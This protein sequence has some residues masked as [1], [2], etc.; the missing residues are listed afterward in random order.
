MFLK[1]GDKVSV[2]GG[3]DR[4]KTGKILQAFPQDELVSV[5]GVN[6]MVKH[7]KKRRQN[8]AGNKIEFP[9]PISIARC[10]LI[11][12]LCGLSS[13]RG[14]KILENGKKERQCKKCHAS[15]R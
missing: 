6:I 1:K 4:G 14:Y 9:A 8:E 2:R 7:L 11:C 13:R 10:Q 5:E 12:P 3:K 15:F